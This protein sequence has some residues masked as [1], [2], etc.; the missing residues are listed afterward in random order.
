MHGLFFMQRA[1]KFTNRL[2]KIYGCV[3]LL[4]YNIITKIGKKGNMILNYTKKQDEYL[5]KY[6]AEICDDHIIDVNEKIKAKDTSPLFSQKPYV[7]IADYDMLAKA[8]SLVNMGR[9]HFEGSKILYVIFISDNPKKNAYLTSTFAKNICAVKSTVLFGQEG[10]K[11]A[12]EIL[13][14]DEILTA[15]HLGYFIRDSI[16]FIEDHQKQNGLT[17]KMQSRF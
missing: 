2:L 4:W 3:T 14:E 10:L 15:K 9:T 5:S 13:T 17:Y 11:R 16:P 1:K 8:K 12:N 7:L 6:I